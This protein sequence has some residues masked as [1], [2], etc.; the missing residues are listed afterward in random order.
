MKSKENAQDKKTG[1]LCSNY[2]YVFPA[3]PGLKTFFFFSLL[4]LN[5]RPTLDGL[6]ETEDITKVYVLHFVKLKLKTKA[7]FLHTQS[8]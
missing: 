8:V 5:F 3:F 4:F 2:H 1:F 6:V 7:A